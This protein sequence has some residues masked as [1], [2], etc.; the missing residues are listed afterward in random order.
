MERFLGIDVGGNHVKTGIVD[1]N[2]EIQ[3]FKTHATADLRKDGKFIENLSDV[4]AFRLINHKEVKKVGIG[5]PGTITKDRKAP[6]EITAIPELNGIPVY[7]LLKK[8]FPDKEFF[9]ENDANAAGLGE[10]IFSKSNTPNTFCFI[11]LGTGIGS[12]AVIDRKIFTGGDGNGLELGHILSRNNLTLE[13]NIGKAGILELIEQRLKEYKGETLVSRT[14]PISATRT[15]VAASQ[16]DDFA[17]SVFFEVGE[18]LG[19][20]LVALIRIM[21]IKTIVI[22]GGLSAAYDF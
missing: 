11:T 10:L 14:E 8:R 2:G 6:I 16:C 4:I 5:F 22:G 17:K 9:L 20:G 12:A 13:Q 15:V 7:D 19:E 21:D 18:L 1:K 3:D